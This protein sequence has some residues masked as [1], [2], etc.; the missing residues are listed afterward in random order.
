MT[1]QFA[2]RAAKIVNYIERNEV[3]H[4]GGTESL[5]EQ[6]TKE[7]S[8]LR[9]KLAE[10]EAALAARVP[11]QM[12]SPSSTTDEFEGEQYRLRQLEDLIISSYEAACANKAQS[13]KI[14]G[15]LAEVPRGRR[16]AG[17]VLSETHKLREV[18]E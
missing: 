17:S 5:L 9:S 14:F 11:E 7:I 12:T 15:A 1:L 3:S 10:T 2:S 18:S 13:Q 16:R 6:Y 8:V 4:N